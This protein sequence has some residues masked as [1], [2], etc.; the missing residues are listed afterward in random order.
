MTCVHGVAF[1]AWVLLLLAQTTLVAAL[2]DPKPGIDP[3]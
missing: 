3:R 1:T 2:T